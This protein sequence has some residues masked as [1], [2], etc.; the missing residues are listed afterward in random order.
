MV[1]KLGFSG[2]YQLFGKN[3]KTMVPNERVRCSKGT[4]IHA[5]GYA[6]SLQYFV[7]YDDNMNAVEICTGDPDDVS[8]SNLDR[9]YSPRIKVGEECRSVDDVFGI[10]LYY[11]E[12]EEI[13]D[14]IIEKSLRRADNLERLKKEK[15]E[16]EA[17]E[18]KEAKETFAERYSFLE[19]AKDRYD[20][21]VVGR[22]IRTELKRNFPGVKF[23]VKKGGYDSYNVEWTDGPTDEAVSDIVCKYK[24]GRFDAYQDYHYSE[25]SPFTDLF[26]GVDY[27]STQREIS[28]EAVEKV[29]K[30]FPDLTAENMRS[31]K[32]G[33]ENAYDIAY[34]S[35]SLD[36]F[37]RC[38][39]Y[40]LD[41]TPEV[42][43]E[44][45]NIEPVSGE[46]SIVDYSE[47]AIAVTGDTKAVKEQLKNLGGKFNA[48]LTCGPG[49]IFSKKK[50]GEV[51]A[52]LGIV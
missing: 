46:F 10:G 23:S 2:S 3:G 52:V 4:K 5:Y 49:W 43:D 22:N 42:K 33:N 15:E 41:F 50:E 6:M 29:R 9:Y 44:P 28:K 24:T 48:K 30:M 26:G 45:T 8:E 31:Y 40:S 51:R 27:V 14:E 47:K 32:F 35:L 38:F 11:D 20:H 12:S 17:R 13:S 39:A 36:E 18:Y 34:R 16:R 1:Q 19:R 25:G 37:Y 21:N 7:V